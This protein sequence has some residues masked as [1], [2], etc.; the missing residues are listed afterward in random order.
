MCP[1]SKAYWKKQKI[2][3]S[4]WKDNIL[5]LNQFVARVYICND[6]TETDLIDKMNKFNDERDHEEWLYSHP[7][8]GGYSTPVPV[9]IQQDFKI[10]N[11]I[12]EKIK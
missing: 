10:L 3:V 7:K 5:P 1:W 4:S 8:H 11:D 2:D 9:L 6:L 12:R